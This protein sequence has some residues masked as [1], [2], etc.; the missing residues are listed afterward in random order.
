MLTGGH[1]LIEIVFLSPF[2]CT[3][4]S[5]F[6]SDFVPCT[7]W[8]LESHTLTATGYLFAVATMQFDCHHLT[9]GDDYQFTV[10]VAAVFCLF[11]V[12][13]RERELDD[14]INQFVDCTRTQLPFGSL[15]GNE[16]MAVLCRACAMLMLTLSNYSENVI[17]FIGK[18]KTVS[19]A[20]EHCRNFRSYRRVGIVCKC[21]RREVV[22]VCV[23]RYRRTIS[24]LS[25][26]TVVLVEC[27]I[28]N[29]NLLNVFSLWRNSETE[30]GRFLVSFDVS[31]HSNACRTLWDEQQC[32][33]SLLSCQSLA[34]DTLALQKMISLNKRNF[35]IAIHCVLCVWGE[36][37]ANSF[38]LNRNLTKAHNP[39]HSQR[40]YGKIR[41]TK[42]LRKRR[43]TTMLQTR[44]LNK[45][46]A[47]CERVTMEIFLCFVI[48]SFH[49]AQKWCQV[50]TCFSRPSNRNER[51]CTVCSFNW[52]H[53]IRMIIIE[54]NVVA[55]R[56]SFFQLKSAGTFGPTVH[57]L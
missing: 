56:W 14:K 21:K 47:L 23:Q 8:I 28:E 18:L 50:T 20:M 36:P 39:T 30:S 44:N 51:E 22:S 17:S 40:R 54:C 4:R 24:K 10:I 52:M 45:S 48:L 41:S 57:A 1:I 5:T 9:V 49:F 37:M 46:C 26:C 6:A 35:A 19:R 34:F 38:M 43:V 16:R 7:I 42:V 25:R 12:V 27:K 15:T 53:D 11:C 13:K 2:W 33:N 3:V 29:G 32:W 55:I 31:F